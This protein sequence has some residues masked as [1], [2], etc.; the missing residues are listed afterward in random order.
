MHLERADTVTVLR[1]RGGKGNAFSAAFLA[2][3]ARAV[4]EVERSD[5]RGLVITGD[6]GFFSVGLALPDLIDLDRDALRT[7][8]D[9]FAYAMRR[10][11]TSP[12]PTVA[13][14][15]GHA[16]AGGTVLALQCDARFAATG[17]YKLGLREVQIGIG[18]P[19][20]VVEPLRLRVP[21]TSLTTLALEGALFGPERGRELGLIDDV[22]A[23]A[24][25]LPRAIARAAELGH[26]PR[27][28]YQQVKASILRPAIEAL[29]RHDATEREKWLD[30]WYAPDAQRLLRDQVAKLRK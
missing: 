5:A 11:L 6:A 25:L 30:T 9:G 17:T 10:V 26:A 28:A 23:P 7:F 22:V 15:D 1:M 21:P 24:D 3:L 29:E 27:V 20:A 2:D 8:I 4:D 12:L 13:A 19:A 16:I 14:I 18:L